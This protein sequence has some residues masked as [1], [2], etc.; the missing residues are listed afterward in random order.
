MFEVTK[1]LREGQMMWITLMD[2][3]YEECNLQKLPLHFQ[4]QQYSY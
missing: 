1:G 2:R 4:Y 3:V